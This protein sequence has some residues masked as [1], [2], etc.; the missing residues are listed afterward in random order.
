MKFRTIA[1]ALVVAIAAS[2]AGYWGFGE[3]R[4]QEQHK[5]VVSL[6]ADASARMREGLSDPSGAKTDPLEHARRLDEHANEVNRGLD[7]LRRVGSAP[8]QGLYDASELYLITARELLRR[9]AASFRQGAAMAQS[10]KALQALMRDAGRRSRGWFG[11]TMRAK[12]DFEKDVFSYRLSVDAMGNLLESLPSARDQLKG[13]VAPGQLLD[14]ALR[15]K[16]YEQARA[17]SKS[18]AD[19]VEQARRFVAQQ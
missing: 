13:H 5:T 3:Y 2:I 10:R 1:I 6:I 17:A 4:K 11:Q 16:A 14:E 8:N 19:E 9:Q 7:T 15:A 12:E 18:A